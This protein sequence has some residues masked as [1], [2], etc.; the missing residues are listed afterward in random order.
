MNSRNEILEDILS[1]TT[2][3]FNPFTDMQVDRL[4]EGVSLAENPTG[5]GIANAINV[6]YGAA[7]G[8]GSDPVQLSVNG[9]LTFNQAGLYRVKAVFQ[10]GRSGGT[11]TS[12]VLFRFLISGS[13]SGRTAGAKLA[14]AA[15]VRYIDIDHWFNV[16]AGAT[17]DTQIM[18]NNVGH[19]SGG[20]FKIAPSDEGVGTWNDVPCAVIAVER[21]IKSI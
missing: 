14:N 10:F 19:N 12:E 21:F 11:G 1:A 2:D 9:R 20:L 7:I 13:Q 6:E 17:L 15:S 3:G 16:P 5:L 8:T 18:R 4:I